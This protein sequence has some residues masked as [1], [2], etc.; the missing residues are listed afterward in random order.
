MRAPGIVPRKRKNLPRVFLARIMHNFLRK[1]RVG[2]RVTI[3]RQELSYEEATLFNLHCLVK[4][5]TDA[6]AQLRLGT[7]LSESE[8]L[9]SR[10]CWCKSRKAS[11]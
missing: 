8:G 3:D 2:Q 5:P 10:A 1:K 7:L 9:R 4:K 6:R 11:W